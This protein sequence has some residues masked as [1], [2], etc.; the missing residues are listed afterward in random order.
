MTNRRDNQKLKETPGRFG[1]LGVF[2][3]CTQGQWL[4]SHYLLQ[5]NS[6]VQSITFSLKMFTKFGAL[7]LKATVQKLPWSF[8][9]SLLAKLILTAWK[10]QLLS[11]RQQ[12]PQVRFWKSPHC[13]V[14]GPTQIQIDLINSYSY[15]Y[16]RNPARFTWC[17]GISELIFQNW[18]HVA[19]FQKKWKTPRNDWPLPEHQE[20]TSPKAEPGNIKETDL[21]SRAAP[22]GRGESARPPSAQPAAAGAAAWAALTFAFSPVPKRSL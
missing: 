19:R 6:T 10:A 13:V 12:G 15:K 21:S 7:R 16:I 11:A 2:R 5:G 22:G 20:Y 8:P 17:T 1:K 18:Q 4:Y 14:N 9:T 3:I